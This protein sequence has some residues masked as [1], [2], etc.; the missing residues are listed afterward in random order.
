MLATLY[1]A[2]TVSLQITNV[3]ILNSPL[4]S[5]RLEVKNSLRLEALSLHS[6]SSTLQTYY[7]IILSFSTKSSDYRF[8]M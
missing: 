5:L 8:L 3:L 6:I 1:G 4:L 7:F 2:T